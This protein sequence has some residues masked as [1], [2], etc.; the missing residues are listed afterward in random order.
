MED[1]NRVFFHELGHFLAREINHLYYN[2]PAV[3]SIDIFPHPLDNE[4]YLGDT[5]IILSADGKENKPPTNETLP[6]YLASSTYGCIFQAYSQNTT[7]EHCFCFNGKDDFDK[8]YGALLANG[9]DWLR[10]DIS[11]MEKEYFKLLKEKGEL[12]EMV[13]LLPDTYLT[14]NGNQNYSVNISKLRENTSIFIKKHHP[15][16]K[17]FVEKYNKMFSDDSPAVRSVR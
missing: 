11:S 16:Y 9:L 17:Q 13:K 3:K 5:K 8:W 4:L 12:D 6:E 2:G 15:I 10:V 1:R 14:D 7:L